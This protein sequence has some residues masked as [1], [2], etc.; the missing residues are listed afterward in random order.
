MLKLDFN[1]DI[2]DCPKQGTASA[3]TRTTTVSPT[4]TSATA[5]NTGI[6]LQPGE[7]SLANTSISPDTQCLVQSAEIAI[8]PTSVKY[9]S[10]I[11]G[12]TSFQT[13]TISN[14][15]TQDL[16]IETLDITGTDHLSFAI[17]E[18]N[19]SDQI[20]PSGEKC[21]V[22]V[23][24]LPTTE[25]DKNAFLHVPSNDPVKGDAFLSLEG[26]GILP[27]TLVGP[28]NHAS[29]SGCSMFDF[30]TFSWETVE[31]FKKYEIEFSPFGSF[32]SLSMIFRSSKTEARMY[33]SPW[34]IALGTPGGTGGAVHWRVVGFRVDGT[35][36]TSDSRTFIV[37]P[38]EP[39][40]DPEISPTGRSSLPAISWENNCNTKFRVVFG[41]DDQFS[42]SKSISLKVKNPVVNEGKFTITL[43]ENQWKSV[44]KLVQDESGSAIY[45]RVESLDGA[46][47]SAVTRTMSFVL[48][49]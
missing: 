41:N 18:D 22:E 33:A 17:V 5:Q 15:G 43:K 32:S 42:K 2:A 6:S 7:G 35:A 4:I 21:L 11:V 10:I 30:P 48:T 19:C 25:G 27:I 26:E 13:V 3:S 47:R 14:T 36:F 16:E 1:G 12:R 40:G 23:L 31:T 46:K 29:F 37:E 38:A 44:R 24:F 8:Q 34:A 49:D 20:L 45:W 39:V 9:G 28:A